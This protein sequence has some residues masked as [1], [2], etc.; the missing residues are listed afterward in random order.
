MLRKQV[1]KTSDDKSFY[2]EFAAYAK[3]NGFAFPNHAP[4]KIRQ[5]YIGV[6]VYKTYFS[7][8]FVRNPFDL[9]VSLY[10]YTKQKELDIFKEK[11]WDL[12]QYQKNIRD[13]TFDDWVTNYN[14]GESQCEWLFSDNGELLVNYIGKTET[15][16]KDF[17]IICGA[18]GVTHEENTRVNVTKRDDYKK[19]Y[20]TSTRKIIEKNY[21]KDFE[22]FGYTF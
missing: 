5:K 20:S 9:V 4:A 2:E 19:Y 22:L 18:I 17:K 14:T 15:Y 1:Q 21:H 8:A 3:E 6:D 13:N 11:G 16:A 12:N 10:E 7:F